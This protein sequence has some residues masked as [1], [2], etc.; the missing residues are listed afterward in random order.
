MT[1]DSSIHRAAILVKC[2]TKHQAEQ[3]LT[4]LEPELL[5]RLS[6]EIQKLD[7]VPQ[8][9]K[10]LAIT[11][12]FE[13]FHQHK[14]EI[15]DSIKTTRESPFQFLC[16]ITAELRHE[17]LVQEHPRMIAL[18][19]T[20]LPVSH[21]SEILNSFEPNQRVSILRRLCRNEN[22]GQ[23][24]VAKLA[25]SLR[26]RM[27]EKL[28]DVFSENNGLETASR[29]LSCMD[30]PTRE[31]LLLSVDDDQELMQDLKSRI[32][33]FESLASLTDVDIRML[34]ART[35]TSLWAPALVHARRHIRKKIFDN[36]AER[37][38]SILK[39][40]IRQA[41]HVDLLV[42]SRAQSSIMRTVLGLLDENLIVLDRQRKRAA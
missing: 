21:A 36:L 26:K 5:R 40:E 29:L 38:R 18:I 32:L 41:S 13:R 34:L 24:E 27:R 3:V 14:S 28:A 39:A 10:H 4:L 37:P 8:S 12:F 15:P 16:S 42:G 31:T 25:E 9:L 20:N 23:A 35:D 33:T 2:L 6:R 11:K 17:L 1:F 7:D 22:F 19:L 30:A